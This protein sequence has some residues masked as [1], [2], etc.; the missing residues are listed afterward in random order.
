MR[1]GPGVFSWSTCQS[2]PFQC[3]RVVLFQ[4]RETESES[5][6]KLPMQVISK[7][8]PE[9]SRHAPHAAADLVRLIGRTG[10]C[11]SRGA[12]NAADG[13]RNVPATY[14]SATNCFTTCSMISALRG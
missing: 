9:S 7:C 6:Y 13:T 2:A 3:Q 5:Y 11:K 14:C 4:V 1:P 10:T 12:S 8:S